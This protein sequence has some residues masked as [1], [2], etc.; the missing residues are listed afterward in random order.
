MVISFFLLAI[1][2]SIHHRHF[3]FIERVD[4][5]LVWLNMWSLLFVIL[6]PFSTTMYGEYHVVPAAA[7]LFEVNILIL[8]LLK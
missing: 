4:S 8:G 1:F 3:N 7:I 5:G 2:W 6:V